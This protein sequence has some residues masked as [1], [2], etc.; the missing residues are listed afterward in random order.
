MSNSQR[1]S[2]WT[3][4]QLLAHIKKLENHQKHGLVW[5]EEQPE[6]QE[7]AAAILVEV[8]DKAIDTGSELIHTLI[9]GDNIHA[10][11]ALHATH[12]KAI[13]LIYID[14]PY[15]RGFREGNESRYNDHYVDGNHNFRHSKWL[16]FM[17]KRLRLARGLLKDTGVIFISIDDNELAP[18]RLLMDKFFG[19]ENYRNT[20]IIRRGAKNVQAQFA[21]IDKLASG[22]EYILF[23]SMNPDQ[24]F[25]KMTRKLENPKQGRWNNHWRGTNRPTMRYELLGVTPSSGQWRWA[26]SR[27]MAAVENYRLLLQE[28]GKE[29]E[30]LSQVEIDEWFL[31]K[32]AGLGKEVDLLRLSSNGKPEHYVPPTDSTLLNDV[33][34]DISP[35]ST[36]I[37]KSMFG[38]KVFYN[39]KPLE[40]IQRLCQFAP[41][42]AVI[43]DFFAGSGTTAHA[44]LELN[45]EDGGHRRVILATNNENGIC[46]EV[47]YPRLE[48]VIT[49]YRNLRGF[50]I[51]GLGGNLKYFRVSPV[52]TCGAGKELAG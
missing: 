8:P 38:T 16:G 18:L 45:K 31:A 42:D 10:L 5:E 35:N 9:E 50:K 26:R 41:K 2:E 24:R 29:T 34:F 32:S 21:T 20:I 33:W 14:P 13:D 46:T 22:Y 12:E 49:G 15:N 52:P 40:L 28:L 1:Y 6:V 39:P 19:E 11:S 23:Y 43:L 30:D 3:R 37:L 4:E 51:P 25:P 36:S 44:V 17:Q 47:C 7:D 48:K 27:S